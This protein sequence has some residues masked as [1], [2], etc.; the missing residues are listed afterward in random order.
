[1]K[2][3]ILN[4]NNEYRA[5]IKRPTNMGDCWLNVYQMAQN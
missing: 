3:V 1:M 5:D 4:W 2:R